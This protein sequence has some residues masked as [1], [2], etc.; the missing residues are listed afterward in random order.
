MAHSWSA[1]SRAG[2]LLPLLPL[3][4]RRQF[5]HRLC[6]HPDERCAPTACMPSPHSLQ[7]RVCAWSWFPGTP[8]RAD[9]RCDIW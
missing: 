3:R 1:A 7:K 8:R 4:P 5:Q 2:A 9:A 6:R